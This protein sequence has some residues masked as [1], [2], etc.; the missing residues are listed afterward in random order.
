MLKKLLPGCED[1]DDDAIASMMTMTMLPVKV[2]LLSLP[3]LELEPP[4]AIQPLILQQVLLHILLALDDD[5]DDDDE[6]EDD[7]GFNEYDDNE[8][9]YSPAL[10][11]N[12]PE[13]RLGWWPSALQG[14]SAG[15]RKTRR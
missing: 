5:D 3:I 2:H 6:D 13:F 12:D 11:R 14:Q 9:N 10:C 15:T 1:D 4:P 7:D 8:D